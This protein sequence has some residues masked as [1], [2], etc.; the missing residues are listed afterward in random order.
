MNSC[1]AIETINSQ[2]WSISNYN[3]ASFTTSDLHR[4]MFIPYLKQRVPMVVAV[5]NCASGF[6]HDYLPQHFTLREI[7][8]VL[9]VHVVIEKY[10]HYYAPSTV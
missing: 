6:S 8:G 1:I 3:S 4:C 9:L 2:K 10:L 7:Y 5:L